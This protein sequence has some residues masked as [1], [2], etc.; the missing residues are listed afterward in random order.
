MFHHALRRRLTRAAILAAASLAVAVPTAPAATT[1]A[2]HGRQLVV[3]E[4]AGTYRMTGSL[5]GAWITTSFTELGTD[6]YVRAEGTE[7]FSGCL[8]V[9]RDGSCAGDPSGTLTFSFL[10]WGLFDGETMI[11]GSCWHPVAGALAGTGAFAGA[12]GVL[13]MVDTPTA[14]GVRTAYTGNLTLKGRIGGASSEARRASAAGTR[15]CGPRR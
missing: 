4:N 6:P 2:V 13:T 7:R 10:Y 12:R 1:V 8:D 3:D 15:T 11:W 14:T 5:R 9:R